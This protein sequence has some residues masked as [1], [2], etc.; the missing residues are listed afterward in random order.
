MHRSSESV[1]VPV[2]LGPEAAAEADLV[3]RRIDQLLESSPIGCIRSGEIHGKV[4]GARLHRERREDEVGPV[5][6]KVELQLR[7][8]STEC[9]RK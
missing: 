2:S 9:H 5:S 1:T 6:R 3:A 7:A 8:A 4:V